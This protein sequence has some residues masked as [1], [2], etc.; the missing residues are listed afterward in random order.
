MTNNHFKDCEICGGFEWKIVYE[1]P[2]RSGVFADIESGF[3]GECSQ[4]G[5]LRL[6]EESC[7]NI[8]VFRTGEYRRKLNQ[9]I[10][11]DSFLEDHEVFQLSVL[12]ALWPHSLRGKTVADIGCAGGAFIDK[13]RGSTKQ[14]VAIEPDENYHASLID[15]GCMVYGSVDQ[16]LIDFRGRVDAAFCLHTIHHV[17]NP[18]VFLDQIRHLL[19]PGSSLFISTPNRNDILGKLIPDDFLPFFYRVAHRWYFDEKSL[20]TCA[21]EAGFDLVSTKFVNTYGMSNLLHWLRDRKPRG[22]DRL[23]GIDKLADNM[24]DA[25]VESSGLAD[26]VYVELKLKAS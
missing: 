11:V 22:F 16:A 25:Y 8:E 23:E 5:V 9:K 18:K 13:I 15:R 17:D 4:C 7:L 14:V 19:K 6:A 2:V 20:N 26:T 3:V 12:K 24:W 10:D 21:S 1:G